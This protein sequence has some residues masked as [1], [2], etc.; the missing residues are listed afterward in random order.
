MLSP[1]L[2]PPLKEGMAQYTWL[3]LL[4][5]PNQD[6]WSYYELLWINPIVFDDFLVSILQVPLV[7]KSLIMNVYKGYNLLIF[8]PVL[9]K[10]CHYSLEG[11]YLALS[12]D[13]DYATLL[14]E[15]DILIF[16]FTRGQMCQFDSYITW[17]S[18]LVSL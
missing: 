4:N 8:H 15:H 17:K 16:V 2:L 1:L 14:L 12:S 6:I 7:D 5:D 3:A 11:E 13:G 10:T 9:Q 18:F